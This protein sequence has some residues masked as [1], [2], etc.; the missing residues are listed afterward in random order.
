MA[1]ELHAWPPIDPTRNQVIFAVGRKGSGKSVSAR[2]LFRSWPGVDRVVLD[3]TGDA[4]PGADMREIRLP[5]PVPARLPEYDKDAGPQVYRWIADPHSDTYRDDLDK[6]LALGLWPKDRAVLM[7]VDEAGEV[8]KANQVGP[9]GRTALHQGR[10]H[11]L[12]LLLCCP[13]PKGIDP[14]CLA[15]ADRVLMYDVPNPGDRERL[16]QALGIKP[17]LLEQELNA[18]RKPHMVNGRQRGGDYWYLMYLA[19]EHELYRCPPLPQGR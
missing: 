19:D 3:V 1:S 15:Q 9:H 4:D 13:R 12:S 2:T 7:W 5:N 14:L 6:A 10:H 16:A 8:F 11:N 17:R 18:T